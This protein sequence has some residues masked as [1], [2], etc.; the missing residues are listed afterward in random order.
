MIPGEHYIAF[1][2]V[3]G[4]LIHGNSGKFLVRTA[5]RKGLISTGNFVHALYLSLLY[6]FHLRKPVKIMAGM[7]GWLNGLSEDTVRQLS[8]EVFQSSISPSIRP[9]VYAEVQHHKDQNARIVILSSAV[10]FVCFPLAKHLGIDDV[11][12]SELEVK[13]GMFTGRF[14]ADLCYGAEKVNRLKAYCKK[15]N[16]SPGMAYYYGDSFSDFQ[17][18]DSVGFPV[19][20]N[21]DKK[22]VKAAT[23]KNWIIHT[24]Q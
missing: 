18:L 8:D 19:C 16:S 5:Y 10:Q 11:I 21:P 23:R 1:F 4:T 9:E 22:L 24:W 2:D 17:A 7:A 12:C 6:R 14:A 13:E 20:I 15:M 3:D